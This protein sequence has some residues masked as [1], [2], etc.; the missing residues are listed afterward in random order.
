M[1]VISLPAP[2]P[3]DAAGPQ[4]GPAPAPL[5]GALHRYFSCLSDLTANPVRW[6]RNTY[7]A[8]FS[9]LLLW[10]ARF[11]STWATW[12]TLS[13]DSGREMYVP[14]MLAQGKMLYRDV[15]YG[16][17]PLAPYLNAFLFRSFGIH[18]NVL[19]WAGSLAALGCALLLFLS[20][21][22]LGSSLAG[23]TA[24][25]ILL[26]ET[27]HAWHF[28]FPLAYSFSAVYGC[29][30]SCLFLW[31]AIHAGASARSRWMLGAATTAAVALLLKLEYGAACYATYALLAAVRA[32][33]QRSA[34]RALM[35]LALCVPG[36]L[37]C[38]LV[39][40][41]MLSIAGFAFI[42]Q[43]NLASTWPGSFF[44]RTYGK[45]WLEKTGLAITGGALL[46]SLARTLFLAGV[47]LEAYLLFW[48]KRFSARWILLQ[49]ALLAGL[50]AYVA[51]ALHGPPLDGLS[52]VLFPQDMVLYIAVVA[53]LAWRHDLLPM[54]V[55]LA[56]A[57]LLALRTLLHTTP[58]G[59][60]I[61]YNG[62]AVLM[63]LILMRPLVPRYGCSRRIVGRREFL[64]GLACLAVAA[65]YSAK[66]SADSFD[67]VPLVTERG[68]V[69]VSSQVA[70]NYRA[71]IRLM[72]QEAAAG[73]PV[74]SVPEDTSLYFLSGTEA[75][76]RLYFFAPGMLVPGKMTRDVI[77]EIDQKPLRYVLWSNRNFSDYGVSRFGTDF[78][79]M[80]GEYLT[81]HYR[82]VGLL[83]PGSDLEWQTRFTLWERQVE[84]QT[85]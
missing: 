34:K 35:D 8:L 17:A 9:L 66:F 52:A 7:A 2:A 45:A 58:W 11:Y 39:A 80:L 60:S 79:Q 67:R 73:R 27:F 38:A 57:A 22:R 6:D 51:L 24:G 55:H 3:T 75:P 30:A 81:S 70:E 69:F 15:W 23:W 28:S 54:A 41:W 40:L 26:M 44:M 33:R 78:D 82:R 13:V 65:L 29:L 77:R 47:I 61:Y 18:L 72:K 21:R 31:F 64:L 85:R 74:L 1:S 50:L 20:G 43:E 16:Y 32:W 68:T 36:V 10:A 84:S 76:S 14:A 4:S 59:Y 83:V 5:P 46:Q 48:R 71:A 49:A 63:F 12:G 53:V 19:Y 25:A 62:P 42:T 37:A 56:F